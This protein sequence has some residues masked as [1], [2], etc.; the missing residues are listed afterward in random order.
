MK[1]LDVMKNRK[2][3]L[4]VS[5]ALLL[6]AIIALVV[7][8][9]N[10]GVDFRGGTLATVKIGESY[11]NEELIAVFTEAG[12]K[13]PVV[14]N[15]D[16]N[17]AIVRFSETTGADIQTVRT[18]ITDALAAKYKSASAPSFETVSA[19]AGQELLLSAGASLLLAIIAI[20]L[21]V[22]RRVDGHAALSAGI[23]LLLVLLVTAGVLACLQTA[24]NT[25]FV[26]SLLCIIVVVMS[27]A[28]VVFDRIRENNKQFDVNKVTRAEVANISARE[29]FPRTLISNL[30]LLFILGAVFV[31]GVSAIQGF[32]LP[33]IIG[34]V[35]SFFA[36]LFIL[37][38]LWEYF[39]SRKKKAR[40]EKKA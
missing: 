7:F 15:A 36:S 12:V 21:Y 8:R 11:K 14:Q 22:W 26:A 32:A 33:V 24:V 5:A 18:N 29:I 20:L 9:L 28:I 4:Y 16:G 13:S 25:T 40:K 6:V 19:T 23:A 1:K 39:L 30:V 38:A 17:T 34:V 2:T 37:P 27:N 35:L 31:F 3:A 10:L